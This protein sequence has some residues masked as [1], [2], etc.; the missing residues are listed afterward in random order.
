MQ[1]EII[2]SKFRKKLCL[3]RSRHRGG[4]MCGVVQLGPWLVELSLAP[5]VT[6]A[7]ADALRSTTVD[8]A[9][10]DNVRV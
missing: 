1:N 2:S 9:A 10:V 4:T 5:A 8:G 6:A 7:D 3:F